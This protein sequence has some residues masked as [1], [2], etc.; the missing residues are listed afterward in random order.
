MK[1]RERTNGRSFARKNMI[2]KLFTLIGFRNKFSIIQMNNFHSMGLSC[3][4][5]LK[6]GQIFHHNLLN[7]S[8]RKNIQEDFHVS[9]IFNVSPATHVIKQH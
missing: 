5:K 8:R 1:K 6:S 2:H 7:K 3:K 9:R 4:N